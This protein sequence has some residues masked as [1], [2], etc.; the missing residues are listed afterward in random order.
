MYLIFVLIDTYITSIQINDANVVYVDSS[1]VIECTIT[2]NT[3]IGPDLSVINYYWY[4]NDTKLNTTNNITYEYNNENTF[5]TRLTITSVQ[6]T[7]GGIYKCEAGIV[8]NQLVNDT[9]DLC[10]QGNDHM[11]INE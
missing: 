8:G 3:A 9:T 6:I 11:T 5:I 7:N 10:V 4:H 1:I 2:L